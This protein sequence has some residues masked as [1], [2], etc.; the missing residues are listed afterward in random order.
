MIL[1][2]STADPGPRRIRPTTRRLRVLAATCAALGASLF[3]AS[4]ADAEPAPTVSL[5]AQQ[6]ASGN[7]VTVTV[8]GCIR[9]NDPEGVAISYL[10]DTEDAGVVSRDEAAI[11]G[12]DATG[13]FQ[14]TL[15]LPSWIG[16]GRFQIGGTCYDDEV[17]GEPN[18]SLPPAALLITPPAAPQNVG[19]ISLGSSVVDPGGSTS[20]RADGLPP[21][22]SLCSLWLDG[23]VVLATITCP[24]SGPL[25]AAAVI[26]PGT[27]AGSH[28]IG[29]YVAA[30]QGI[31]VASAPITVG[32][33]ASTPTT[34]SAPS[35]TATPRA[36]STAAA[37]PTRSAASSSP[38][39]P[40]RVR[41]L[42]A[43]G[44]TSAPLVAVGVL[45]VLLGLVL[46]GGARSANA[47]GSR[48]VSR[49]TPPR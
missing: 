47:P 37:A 6:V 19:T 7:Q 2:V 28:R 21:H 13:T 27:P 48:W 46:C 29:A 12:A 11:G 8:T 10:A 4:P 38:S 45:L 44:T 49:L 42:A 43:T 22:E 1:R 15:T 40:V 9:G 14:R 26:P 18:V 24:T 25:T 5:S 20:V 16:I 33:V 36:A 30:N 3:T 39:S 34:T 17:G 41:A 23:A 35:P 32:P 31:V